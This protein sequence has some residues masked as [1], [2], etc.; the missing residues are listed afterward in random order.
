MN[1]PS[2]PNPEPNPEPGTR[3]PRRLDASSR[4]RPRK[5]R[6][7]AGADTDPAVLLDQLARALDARAHLPERESPLSRIPFV[8]ELPRSAKTSP[9]ASLSLGSEMDSM[10]TRL[11]MNADLSW[12][13]PMRAPEGVEAN[14][15]FP[16]Q[17]DYRVQSNQFAGG[18]SILYYVSPDPFF[19]NGNDRLVQVERVSADRSVEGDHAG[20]S[21][22]ITLN[23]PGTYYVFARV[24]SNRFVREVDNANNL[25]APLRVDVV[26]SGATP[27]APSADSR[28]VYVSSSRGND[29]NSGLS[30]DAPVR[31][32]AKAKTLLRD[33]MPDWML[34]QRGDVFF[35]SLGQWRASGRSEAEPMVVSAFGVGDRPLLKTG[36][37][38]GIVTSGGGGSP[39]RINNLAVV[40]LSFHAHTR[41]PRDPAYAGNAGSD[42]VF[43]LR[44]TT[45]VLFED[46]VFDSYKNGMVFQDFDNLGIQNVKIRRNIV[47]NSY[48]TDTHSQGLYASRVHGLL[49][50]GNLFDRNGWNDLVPNAGPTMFNHNIYIQTDTSGVVLKDNIIARGA[51]HGAQLRT[52][53]IATGNLF[54]NNAINLLM[55]IV[56]SGVAENNVVLK[57]RD[58]NPG[59]LR[60]WGIDVDPNDGTLVRNNIVA[61]SVSDNR[62]QMAIRQRDNAAYNDNIVFNWGTPAAA[63]SNPSPDV[64]A[65]APFRDPTR[66]EARYNAEWGGSAPTLEDFLAQAARQSRSNF[67]A[68][69]TA[70]AVIAYIREGFQ[71][72]A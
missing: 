68:E 26:E 1:V 70:A 43:W 6:R 63:V 29:A 17:R 14:A 51:S 40:G 28:L 67:R 59:L 19:G 36:T 27:L 13:A 41:D 38:P 16:L 61:Q 45:G 71:R 2:N 50:E 12:A 18:L 35:E 72:V 30:P 15:S 57:G 48:S 66:D 58:I 54:L 3:H 11:M 10:E 56:G 5:R 39:A 55:G 49:I 7:K 32:I 44:G 21:P 60:G 64:N 34:L 69:Y 65:A 53:G 33:G 42:G 37:Q 20:L 4:S 46:N 23:A 25:S 62:H 24:M 31:T 47:V 22:R 52:G 9:T 8:D